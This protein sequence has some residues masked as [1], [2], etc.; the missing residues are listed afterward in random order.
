[1]TRSLSGNPGYVHGIE[2][3]AVANLSVDNFLRPSSGERHST[4]EEFHQAELVSI[5][6]D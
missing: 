5:C 2:D 6:L 1:M 4:A 3:V